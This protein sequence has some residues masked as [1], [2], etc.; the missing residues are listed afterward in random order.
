MADKDIT[1][2]IKTTGAD[3][4]AGEVRKVETSMEDLANQKASVDIQTTGAAAAAAEIEKVKSKAKGSSATIDI[5]TTGTDKAASDISKVDKALDGVGKDTTIGI[6]TTGTDAAVGAISKVDK[7]LNAVKPSASQA[8]AALEKLGT[9]ARQLKPPL[10]SATRATDQLNRALG[11]TKGKARVAEFAHYDLNEEIKKTTVST[12][13]FTAGQTKL[14]TGTRNSSQAL[15]MF[16]QGFEDAQ[17]GIRG[18]LNNIP[19]LVI[20]LGGTAG[21]AG[22]ISIAA[23]A[24]SQL[25]PLFSATG[26]SAEELEE[27]AKKTAER[28][29][30]VA[31]NMG[32]LE[33]E[34]FDAVLQEFED[35]RAAGEAVKDQTDLTKAAD[36]SYALSALDNAGKVDGA[37]RNL[38]ASLG[39]QIDKTKE[40]QALAAAEQAKRELVAAQAIEVENTK[41][42]KA[43]E[44]QTKASDILGTE[45]ANL[46]VEKGRLVYQQARLE[47]LRKERDELQKISEQRA[48]DDPGLQLLGTVFPKV[49]P[50]TAAA[51]TA[52]SQL[53]SQDFQ[54]E[55]E[56]TL[57]EIEVLNT[58]IKTHSRAITG[59]TNALN[60][61]IQTRED[62]ESAVGTK[63]E[64]LN[65]SL[66]AST[67]VAESEQLLQTQQ[68]TAAKLTEVYGE[69]KTTNEAGEIAKQTILQAASDGKVT[70][71]EQVGIADDVRVVIAQIQ[72]RQASTKGNVQEL[73]NLQKEMG[74]QAIRDA[75]L[76]R[77]H[78]LQIQELYRRLR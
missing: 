4:A 15:L 53:N 42:E 77:Q 22:G 31:T 32:E 64:E 35:L 55:L 37:I 1:I 67:L 78:T 25:G 19:G 8:D 50:R 41:L 49:I 7:A 26:E 51:D 65:T 63:I 45:E 61:A 17:Y 29:K 13:S 44:A 76:I 16:S 20:A 52:L 58:K 23:V 57:S 43:Q 9:G 6:K 18:V 11:D 5:Q 74:E 59:M 48:T 39:I 28:I 71:D 21:L 30:E 10:D 54:S 47:A 72:S 14:Q 2:G 3:S 68:A 46:N 33:G 38:I 62:V 73:I 24:L 60:L 12:G 40:L 27:K 75:E 66:A 69:I 34:R 70:A 56:G 36:A